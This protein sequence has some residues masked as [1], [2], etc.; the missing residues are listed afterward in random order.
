MG[1]S[2]VASLTNFKKMWLSYATYEEEGKT[3][4]NLTK[5]KQKNFILTIRFYRNLGVGAVH[6]QFF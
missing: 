2:I 5:K 6:R 3:K 1:G 4:S